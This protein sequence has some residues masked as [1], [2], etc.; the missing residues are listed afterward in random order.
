MTFGWAEYAV[1]GFGW[2]WD[3]VVG[4]EVCDEVVEF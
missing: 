1:V 3:E 2:V 4:V